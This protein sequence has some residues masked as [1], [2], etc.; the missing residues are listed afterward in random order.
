[1]TE[2]APIMIH[3]V[4]FE[5]FLHSFII[6]SYL[7]QRRLGISFEGDNNF[8][9]LPMQKPGTPLSLQQSS[10]E[11]FFVVDAASIILVGVCFVVDRAVVEDR[12]SVVVAAS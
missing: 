5:S 7:S 11:T 8:M 9:H 12:C 3:I 4:P 2:T 6:S 1:M 10:K